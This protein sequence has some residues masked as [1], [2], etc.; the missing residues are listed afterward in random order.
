MLTII[1][2]THRKGNATQHIANYYFN[3]LSK[4]NEQV[5]LMA[6]EDLP[7]NF[8][9]Q[10][11]VF[12]GNNPEFQKIVDDFVIKADKFLFIMPEYNGGFPGM[13]KTFIDAVPPKYFRGKKAAMTG[14]AS[15]RAGN[16]RGMEHL[17]GVLNYLDVAVLPMRL[18]ISSIH[19]LL[20]ENNEL[21]DLETKKVISLQIEK[22]LSF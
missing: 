8:M 14:I 4:S 21:S 18:P 15:G 20:D 17:T 13:L 7:Q 6:L 16:L 12:G 5:S 3:Y 19:T 22:F 1:I 9:F 10:N 11:E 2:G